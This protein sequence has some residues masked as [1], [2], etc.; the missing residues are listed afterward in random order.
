MPAWKGK[1]SLP[2][3]RA[4][5]KGPLLR[6]R[7][8]PHRADPST[9]PGPILL[10]VQA[11]QA[12]LG[13]LPQ[14]RAA[15]KG[16]LLRHRLCSPRAAPSTPPRP[17]TAP[18]SG[19]SGAPRPERDAPA[20]RAS[21]AA[22]TDATALR[23]RTRLRFLVHGSTFPRHRASERVNA[24][25]HQDL[26]P[27]SSAD[28][29]VRLPSRQPILSASAKAEVGGARG[30]S[31]RCRGGLLRRRLVQ[32][33]DLTTPRQFQADAYGGC[34][35]FLGQRPCRASGTRRRPPTATA[36]SCCGP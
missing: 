4:A 26:T 20:P 33:V 2:Q 22:A 24:L 35:E 8:C 29:C 11:V 19:C 18:R 10:L 27:T 13:L 9:P 30:L 1:A 17:E 31:G 16:P 34:D 25:L 5:T 14:T 15:T 6:H 32:S 12:R 36:S 28:T 23:V 7:L 3:T 21:F